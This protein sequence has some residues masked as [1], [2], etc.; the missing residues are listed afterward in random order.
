MG[1]FDAVVGEGKEEKY[2]GHY[3]L[4]HRNQR[5]E[6]L[7]EFCRIRQM[8]ISNTWF[9]QDKQR[10]YIWTTPGD[11]GRYQIGYLLMNSRYWNSVTNAKTY[12]G[13]DIDLIVIQW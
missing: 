5:G 1:D 4:G 11:I 12:S 2:I 7:V 9:S 13:A 8:Y 10:R 6:K 3:G